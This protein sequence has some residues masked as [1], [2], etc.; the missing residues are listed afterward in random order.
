M[1]GQMK[2]YEDAK[3]VLDEANKNIAEF[4]SVYLAARRDEDI[5]RVPRVK[6]K[7]AIE[8]L[9]SALEFTSQGIWASYTRKKNKVYFPYGKSEKDFNV[10]LRK[11]LPALQQEA[12]ILFNL[13]RGMQPH[14]CGDMWLYDLCRFSN[15]NKHNGLS[16]QERKNSPGSTVH[17]PGFGTFGAEN[18]V[19][20][21][22]FVDGVRVEKNGSMVFTNSTTTQEMRDQLNGGFELVREFDWVEFHLDITG[23]DALELLKKAYP[24]ICEFVESVNKHICASAH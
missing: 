10:S 2:R 22:N 1:I 19:F 8:N 18:M 11:S 24:Q 16:I 7:P 3:E 4:E 17:I 23:A 9:R 14:V 21:N 15:F 5:D 6:L 20:E 13:V 12:P